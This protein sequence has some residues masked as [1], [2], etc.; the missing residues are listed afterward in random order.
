MHLSLQ[1]RRLDQFDKE[2]LGMLK[3]EEDEFESFGKLVAAKVRR[4]AEK[5][6]KSAIELQQFISNKLMDVEL[7]LLDD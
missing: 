4:V 6:R 2:L 5:S 3:T 1:K 7:S